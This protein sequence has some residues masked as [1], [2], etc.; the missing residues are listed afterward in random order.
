M[1]FIGT[2]RVKWPGLILAIAIIVAGP[3]LGIVVGLVLSALALPKDP[4]PGDGILV[5]IYVFASVAAS[6]P[7][8]ISLALFALLREPKTESAAHATL[9]AASPP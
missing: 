4:A 8:S 9:G 2:L 7:L 6:I 3:L 1:S 5:M